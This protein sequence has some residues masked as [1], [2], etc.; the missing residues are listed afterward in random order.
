VPVGVLRDDDMN[1]GVVE[2]D[3]P[4]LRGRGESSQSRRLA[5]KQD[6]DP[7]SLFR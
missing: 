7:A 3:E 1:L 2:P 5:G 4:G 6:R